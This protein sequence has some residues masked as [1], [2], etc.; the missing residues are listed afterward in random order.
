[1]FPAVQHSGHTQSPFYLDHDFT[2]HT[3]NVLIHFGLDRV[4]VFPISFLPLVVGTSAS[5]HFS[6]CGER[7]L[8]LGLKYI[9]ELIIETP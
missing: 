3:P 5:F 2:L 4:L 8:G 7:G 9:S 1:M 6:P